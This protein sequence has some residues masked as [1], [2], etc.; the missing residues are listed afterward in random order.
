MK[1]DSI[2]AFP[3]PARSVFV[4]IRTDAGITG[5]G[6]GSL[7]GKART[8][9]AL[10]G[11]YART[12]VGR[13]PLRIEDIWQS[14]YRGGFYRGGPV[15]MS[16]MS[17]IDQALWDILGK[18]LGVPAHQLMGGAVRERIRVYRWARGKTPEEL[19]EDGQR[20]EAEGYTLM[21]IGVVPPSA[22]VAGYNMVKKAVET[23]S[24]LRAALKPETDIAVDF[25]GRLT[26]GAAIQ[27]CRALEE[28]G[29]LFIEEPVIPSNIDALA[30]VA[31]ATATPIAAGE[32]AYGRADF[33]EIFEKRAVSVA[34]PD[35]A[36][37]GGLWEGRK[38]AAM[39]EVCQV[40][41]APHNPLGAINLAASLQLDACT[42]NFVAQELVELGE[43]TLTEP[44]Q[45]KNG[46]I[47]TPVKPGL[48]VEVDEKALET[49]RWEDW[50]SPV[51]RLADGT[52][53]DW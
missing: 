29:L 11:E 31:H 23:V 32:R 12:L 41:V 15:M 49:L 8:I 53:V 33:R 24:A 7:E 20:L 52:V 19:A 39:A 30:Q 44:F 21:K 3:V 38:I 40:G 26:A 50:E 9:V 1:I 35:L 25:H 2:E 45:I 37:A 51:E 48:G 46:F 6:E 14:L 10:I 22:P 47:E 36:H 4:R 17:G 42:P 34:Q 28:F 13:D 43:K 18:H 16:A 5:Y 27:V